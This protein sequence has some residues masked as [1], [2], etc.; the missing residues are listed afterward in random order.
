MKRKKVRGFGSIKENAGLHR[1][2]K[3]SGKD[4]LGKLMRKHSAIQDYLFTLLINSDWVYE[5][6]DFSIEEFSDIT[7]A[8]LDEML[9]EINRIASAR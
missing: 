9:D 1:A 6:M 8:D 3:I 2:K 4:N 7:G 5:D